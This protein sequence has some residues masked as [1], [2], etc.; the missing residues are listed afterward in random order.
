[1]PLN[2]PLT[3]VDDVVD[4]LHGVLV[5]DPY[6]WLESADDPETRNWITAQNGVTERF[7]AGVPAREAIRA[8]LS[9]LWDY[10][11]YDVPLARGGQWFQWRNTGLQDQPVLYVGPAAGSE[12]RPLLDPNTLSKDGTVAI[13]GVSVSEDGSLLAY[14]TSAAG[15]DWKTWHL[16]D[17]ASGNDRDDV[18][19]WSKFSGAA[20]RRDGSGF[21]YAA[22][23]RPDPGR[24]FDAENRSPRI[25]FHR[26]G[27]PAEHDVTVYAAPEHPDWLPTAVVTEDDRYLIVSIQRGTESGVRDRGARPAA[28]RVGVSDAGRRLRYQSGRGRQCRLDL[29]R[30]HRPRC[31]SGPGRRHRPHRARPTPLEGGPARAGRH[32]PRSPR[33]RGPAGLPLSAPRPVAA[34]GFTSW[35]APW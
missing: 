19:E 9:T 2:Y 8:R 23:A 27:T 21:Y 15:S 31:R 34:C 30:G 6:R 14:A 22:M 33:L 17:V 26:I 24:E 18:I 35:T 12:G 1:M 20:W 7:L 25:R 29:F 28:S 10:P 3:R 16:R 13:T 4:D 5:A 32:R 11:R